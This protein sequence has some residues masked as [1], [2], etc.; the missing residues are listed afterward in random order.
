MAGSQPER[1][2]S[3]K[4]VKMNWRKVHFLVSDV[5]YVAYPDTPLNSKSIRLD[6]SDQGQKGGVS[7]ESR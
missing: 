4:Q 5:N 6:S 3:Q 2:S 1:K 7:S